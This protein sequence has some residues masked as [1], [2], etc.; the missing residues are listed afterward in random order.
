MI[1]LQVR[2]SVFEDLKSLYICCL[3]TYT[4]PLTVIMPPYLHPLTLES[5]CAFLINMSHQNTHSS[6]PS[7]HQSP[8]TIPA[9]PSSTRTNHTKTLNPYP[10]P[11]ST[12]RD[13]KTFHSYSSRQLSNA[14]ANR[15]HSLQIAMKCLISKTTTGR[16]RRVSVNVQKRERCR[17]PYRRLRGGDAPLPL[18][19][20]AGLQGG[21]S[22]PSCLPC[23]D[24]MGA[25]WRLQRRRASVP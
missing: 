12:R 10:P 11:P 1:I 5:Y 19:A 23:S 21:I 9:P 13:L 4:H 8:T 7:P 15:R 16:Q 20:N 14:G 2:A 22:T 6:P 17:L 25:L 24:R 18:S 3:S